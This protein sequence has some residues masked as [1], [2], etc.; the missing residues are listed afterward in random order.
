VRT[1]Q[2]LIISYERL[3]IVLPGRFFIFSFLFIFFY[4]KNWEEC[5]LQAILLSSLAEYIYLSRGIVNLQ[6]YLLLLVV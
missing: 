4:L 1:R 5:L 3:K 2:N 6:L